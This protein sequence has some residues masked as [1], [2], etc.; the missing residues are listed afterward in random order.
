MFSYHNCF[1]AIPKKS[2]KGFLDCQHLRKLHV[3]SA[4]TTSSY[5]KWLFRTL[6]KGTVQRGEKILGDQSVDRRD[7]PFQAVEDFE[8][9]LVSL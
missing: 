6:E 4:T 3:E 7:R 5:S 1:T 2:Q 9:G 8:E